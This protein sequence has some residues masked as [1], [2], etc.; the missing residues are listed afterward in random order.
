MTADEFLEVIKAYAAQRGIQ[1]DMIAFTTSG[2]MQCIWE[3]PPYDDDLAEEY[4]QQ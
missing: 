4:M 3:L 2:G 1:L